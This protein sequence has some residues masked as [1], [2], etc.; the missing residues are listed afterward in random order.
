[1]QAKR[2]IYKGYQ[3]KSRLEAKYTLF[4]DHLCIPYLYEVETFDLDGVTYTPDFW[5]P[6]LE[7]WIEV[8]GDLI[9]DAQGLAMINKCERLAVQS[10]HPVLL[11]FRD[12]LDSRCALFSIRG[13]MFSDA[14]FQACPE[15]G[16][17]T[18][19]VRTNTGLHTLCRD[20]HSGDM[21][22]VPFDASLTLH[23]AA[24]AARQREFRT[25]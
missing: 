1:M 14:G 21:A 12:P 15:C 11:T 24:V 2:T 13:K 6:S 17:A 25:K 7:L 5:L 23:T 4:L 20:L 8:K 3:S 10:S 16:R 19:G 18:V 9:T 22:P